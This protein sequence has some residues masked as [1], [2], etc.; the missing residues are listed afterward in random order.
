MCV[1]NLFLGSA[2]FEQKCDSTLFTK[3]LWYMATCFPYFNDFPVEFVLLRM[4][5]YAHFD[6]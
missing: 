4:Q 5:K 6:P 2:Y 3:I 1:A